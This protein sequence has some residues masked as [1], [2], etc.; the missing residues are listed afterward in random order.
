MKKITILG[1]TVHLLDRQ[2]LKARIMV[3]LESQSAHQIITVNPEFIVRAYRDPG[4]QNILANANLALPDGTGLLLAA[5]LQG[6]KARFSDRIPGADLTQELLTIAEHAN[7]RVAIILKNNSLSS[8]E[9]LTQ[10]LRNL[11]PTLNVALFREPTSVEAIAA[12]KPHMLFAALGSPTQ[13]VWIHDSMA[14]IPGLRIAMGVGGTFDFISGKIQ[15]A[16][17]CMRSIGLE[18]LWRLI[19][20]PKRLPRILRALIVFPY[21]VLTKK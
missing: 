16:P 5:W 9:N 6:V 15:R 7:Y 19:L 12:Y 8:E 2:E 1:I 13:E 11:Y 21:L 4:Y 17:K 10:K 20:E 14:H 3:M 18:W